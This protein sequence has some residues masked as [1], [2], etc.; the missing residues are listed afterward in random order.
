M[1]GF[2]YKILYFYLFYLCFF[3]LESVYIDIFFYDGPIS[4]DMGFGDVLTSWTVWAHR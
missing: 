2:I 1:T 3:I 4:G